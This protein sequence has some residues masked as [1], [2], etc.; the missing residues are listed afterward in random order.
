MRREKNN[1]SLSRQS[2]LK[3]QHLNLNVHI[4]TYFMA[5]LAVGRMQLKF[6]YLSLRAKSSFSPHLEHNFPEAA[7]SLHILTV[8][9]P[10]IGILAS[11]KAQL[12]LRAITALFIIIDSQPS[13]TLL[14]QLA[15]FIIRT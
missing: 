6:L 1:E 2:N 3:L 14:L 7:L 9:A 8:G 11:S 13:V 4:Y 5:R 15:M 10:I 12:K